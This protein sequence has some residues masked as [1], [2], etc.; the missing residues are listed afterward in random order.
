VLRG[1]AGN[2]A[3]QFGLGAAAREE[4]EFLGEGHVGGK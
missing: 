3:S 1:E 4:V 2:T